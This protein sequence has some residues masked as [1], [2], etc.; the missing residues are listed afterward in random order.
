MQTSLSSYRQIVSAHQ[1]VLVSMN[2]KLYSN[3][4][5]VFELKSTELV[6][7]YTLSLI[8]EILKNA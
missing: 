7:K 2:E 6:A 3:A 5:A 4:K 1:Q 8:D